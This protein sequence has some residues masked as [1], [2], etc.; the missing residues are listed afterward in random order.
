MCILLFYHLFFLRNA[1]VLC[2]GK[3]GIEVAAATF[4][5]D[6]RLGNALPNVVRT[7]TH[8]RRVLL[9]A[10][11]TSDVIHEA[12]LMFFG[13]IGNDESNA[14]RVQYRVIFILDSL[15][16]ECVNFLLHYEASYVHWKPQK[17]AFVLL[18]YLCKARHRS[19]CLCC[20]CE[21]DAFSCRPSRSAM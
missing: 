3:M 4:A 6:C 10:V 13:G 8:T 20:V 16:T 19:K 11:L 12:S 17:T 9:Q 14:R 21:Q 7:S 18:L 1:I 2:V 15:F 5:T